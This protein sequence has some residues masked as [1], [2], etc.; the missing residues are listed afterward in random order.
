MF[1]REQMKLRSGQ[2]LFLRLGYIE[3]AEQYLIE[4]THKELAASATSTSTGIT[5]SAIAF[6]A[7]AVMF[8][9]AMVVLAGNG[10]II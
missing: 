2:S 3:T 9:S 10:T 1:G 8:M 7:Y 6:T 4:R 5:Q